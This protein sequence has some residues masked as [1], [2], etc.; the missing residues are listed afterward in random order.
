ML[1]RIITIQN[2]VALFVLPVFVAGN[3]SACSADDLTSSATSSGETGLIE[4]TPEALFDA[5]RES[6]L[7]CQVQARINTSNHEQNVRFIDLVKTHFTDQEIARVIDRRERGCVDVAQAVSGESGIGQSCQAVTGTYK[8]QFIPERKSDSGYYPITFY[9]DS[10][11]YGWMCN[12]GAP[13]EF[14][15]VI[16]QFHV[17]GAYSDLSSLRIYGTSPIGSCII[18]DPTA[19]RVYSD[20]DIRACIGYHHVFFCTLGNFTVYS[21]DMKMWR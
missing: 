11:A 17:P 7:T 12:D 5:F 2:L 20:D 6:G 4:T 9:R 10:S 13:E 14:A 19:A 21:S 16:A 1:A 15:D 18:N 3:L 8:V